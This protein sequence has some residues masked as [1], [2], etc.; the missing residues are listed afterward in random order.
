MTKISTLSSISWIAFSIVLLSCSA[1]VS[2]DTDVGDNSS[3]SMIEDSVAENESSSVSENS[4]DSDE[5]SIAKNESVDSES[6]DGEPSSQ[7]DGE[8]SESSSSVE[9]SSSTAV[10]YVGVVTLEL[11]NAETDEKIATFTDGYTIDFEQIGTQKITIVAKVDGTVETVQFTYDSD[12]SYQAEANAPYAIRGDDGGDY[13]AWTPES[14]MHT[15]AVQAFNSDGAIGDEVVITFDVLEFEVEAGEPFTIIAIPDTQTFSIS[16]KGA[17]PGMWNSQFQWVKDNIGPLNI[18]FVTHLGDIVDMW[19]DGYY[20]NVQEREWQPAV[21]AFNLIHGEV[22]YGVTPGNHDANDWTSGSNDWSSYDHNFGVSRFDG[23]DWYAEN[24]NKNRNSVQLFSGGGMDF[25]VL[26]IRV[27]P[28]DDELDWGKSMLDKYSDKRAIVV[29][30]EID[31]RGEGGRG[32]FTGPGE[33]IWN[34]VKSH[35]NVFMMLSGHHCGRES[36]RIETGSSGNSI[37]I[38]MSDYQCDE[39]QQA[40]LRIYNFVPTENKIDVKTYSPWIKQY[41]SDWDSEF[42]LEYQMN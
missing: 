20:H 28:S 29:S 18:K 21:N 14:G 2:L 25:M 24:Y 35:D 41:E 13:N 16:N 37:H 34:A 17:N 27:W 26:H 22:P 9:E 31:Q 40:F 23:M 42:S 10:A 5:S 1:E 39:P 12:D 6:S 11:Y 3:S 4:S 8:S 7:V 15:L 30:H 33:S 32:Y 36:Q 38:I 19:P